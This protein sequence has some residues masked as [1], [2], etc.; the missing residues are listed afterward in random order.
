MKIRDGFVSNSS[1]SS[2]LVKD[3][4]SEREVKE[5]MGKIVDAWNT[6]SE[7]EQKC[8]DH[9]WEVV[10]LSAED[11]KDIKDYYGVDCHENQ[12]M[13]KSASD[14]SIPYGIV[15]LLEHVRWLKYFHRG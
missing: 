15:S 9:D 7:N 1:C 6:V 3:N 10:T 11:V 4:R 8:Y 12:I 13:I 2:F 14:N 5:I